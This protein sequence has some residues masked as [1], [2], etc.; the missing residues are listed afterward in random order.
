MRQVPKKILLGITGSIAAYKIPELIR[1]LRAQNYDVK[2][3]MT[4]AAKSFVTPL[5]LQCLSNN[6]VYEKLLDPEVEMT[7]GHIELARWADLILI[8]HAS[9]NCIAKLA[10]GMADDL[11]STLCLVAQCPIMLAP[12]M[13][14]QMWL[15]LATQDNIKILQQ[16]GIQIWGPAS[17]EQACGEVGPGRMLEPEEIVKHLDDAICSLPCATARGRVRVGALRVLIT[18]GPTQEPLDPV[19]FLSNHSSGKMGYSLAQAFVEHGA[20]VILISGPTNLEP[21]ANL[22]KFISVTTAQEML[23]QVLENM[24]NIDTLISAA[25]VADYRP[26]HVSA[27]KIK[28]NTESL[29]LKLE[30]NPDILKAVRTQY[31]NVFLVGF[32]LET[33]NL[34]ANAEHKLN[35]K[36]LDMIIANQVSESN[37]I[38]GE[39]NNSV[40]VLRKDGERVEF[41][42]SSKQMLAEQLVDLII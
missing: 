22:E 33:E 2:I 38:F 6:P 20:K 37:P 3:V 7:M 27:H 25:A 5:T 8:A 11:L 19:R 12:A 41:P 28:K 29:A 34:I 14:Q 24:S 32:A 39:N 35:D 42:M 40:T 4:K 36:Q 23:D 17:G 18:A 31:P 10:H 9:A 21:P 13:N 1:Q 30:K 26:V 15:N 16:R